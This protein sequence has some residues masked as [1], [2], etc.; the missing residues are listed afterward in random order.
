MKY[1]V[2]IADGAAGWALPDRGN[3]TCLEMA[4]TPNLD[5]M[6]RGGI[7]GLA[8]TVPS[9]MEPS[10]ACACMSVLGYDPS[11]YYRGRAGIEAAGAEV[12]AATFLRSFLALRGCESLQASR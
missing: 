7:L 8:R 9:G 11:V 3:K 6:A 10:S 12:D 1:C 2:V 5:A 4:H